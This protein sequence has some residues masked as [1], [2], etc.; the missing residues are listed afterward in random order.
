MSHRTR[1]RLGIGLAL[2]IAFCPFLL[3]NAGQ[4]RPKKGAATA[5][6]FTGNV[7]SLSGPLEKFG[8][9][10]DQAAAPHWLALVTKDGKVYPL[11]PDNGSL[12]FFKDPSLRNRL[13]RLTGRLFA[14]T[15][16]LQ[17]LAV[18]SYKVGKLHEVYYWC[19]ICSIRRAAPGICE[20]CGGPMELREVPAK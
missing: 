15:H 19:D 1:R 8:A 20:C 9:R 4:K 3:A 11:I 5:E 7:V 14:G 6:T 18:H 10:L 12:L 13:V 2:T 17:V 16:L